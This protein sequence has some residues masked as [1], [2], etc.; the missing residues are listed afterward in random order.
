[1]TT[2]GR[3]LPPVLARIPWWLA[4][5][6][7]IAAYLCLKYWLPQLAGSAGLLPLA[8]FLPKTAPLAAIGFLLL[9]AVLLYDG[10]ENEPKE[11]PED[12]NDQDD[13]DDRND[14]DDRDPGVDRGGP[15]AP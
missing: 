14:R 15:A 13:W 5:M 3:K 7:A 2:T 9:A 4:V 10:D 6:L 12:R 8:A 1:M 11:P